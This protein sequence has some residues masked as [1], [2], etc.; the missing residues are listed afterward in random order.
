MENLRHREGIASG[1]IKELLKKT[2][3]EMK[4]NI[5]E[6]QLEQFEAYYALLME[7]NQKMNLTAIIK[8]ED[9]VTK[10]FADSL[11]LLLFYDIPTGHAWIDIGAGAGFPGIPLKIMRPDSHSVLA[12][13]LKKRI[14]FLDTVK[15]KLKLEQIQCIHSRA[16]D[17]GRNPLYREQMDL[18][19]ARAVASL[20][21]LCEYGLPFVKAGGLMAAYKGPGAEDEVNEAKTIINILGGK[22]EEIHSVKLP[23]SNIEHQLVFI[24]KLSQIPAKYPRSAGKIKK[25]RIT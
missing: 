7:W 18:C 4:L 9:V 21:I 20:D 19:V 1:A 3:D 25:N 14:G 12:D 16:E 10:H 17:L 24:R 13:S 6:Q 5:S 22:V 11:S 23:F 8:P 15:D 2:L